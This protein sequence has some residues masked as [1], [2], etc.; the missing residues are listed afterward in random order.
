MVDPSPDF[1]RVKQVDE[2]FYVPLDEPVD[3]SWR[4]AFE[5]VVGES[6]WARAANVSFGISGNDQRSVPPM[7]EGFVSF[8]LAGIPSGKPSAGCGSW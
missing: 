1:I 8:E 6:D 5:S 7:L 4:F 3:V 2:K